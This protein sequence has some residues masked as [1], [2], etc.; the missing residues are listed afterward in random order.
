MAAPIPT[1]LNVD[2]SEDDIV[3]LRAACA[4]SKVTFCLQSLN[5]GYEA[6]H[7]LQ[8]VQSYA[9][10]ERFPFPALL[11]LDLKM[12][13]TSGFEVLQFLRSPKHESL[14]LPIV[15][16]TSS[17]HD[18]DATRAFQLGADAYVVKPSDFDELRRVVTTLDTILS[19]PE[20]DLSDL[21]HL[22]DTKLAATDA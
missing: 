5:S 20:P 4:S 18:E 21:R 16:F 3:M 7:Y 9:D 2:D 17:M 15:V 12:P 8:G 11:L 6:L 19:R 1:I 14:R 13:G 10:R 22:P